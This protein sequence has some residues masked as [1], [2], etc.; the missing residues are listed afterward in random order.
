MTAGRGITHSERF[1]GPIR[2]HGG[3]VDAGKAHGV[4]FVGRKLERRDAACRQPGDVLDVAVLPDGS[5]E[6]HVHMRGALH[7]ADLLEKDCRVRHRRRHVVGHVHAGGDAAGRGGA[8]GALDAGPADG[9]RGVHVAVHKPGQDEA[10]GVVV[11]VRGRGRRA[12]A[13]GRDPFAARSDVA[14]PQHA[15]ARHDVAK[16]DAVEVHGAPANGRMRQ[17]RQGARVRQ[18]APLLRPRYL[19]SVVPGK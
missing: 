11:D 14:A 6:R 9:R 5:V 3:V 2:E 17:R 4:V 10:A 16:K 12:A 13:Y 7:P 18:R 15:R 19:K 8:R 1:D